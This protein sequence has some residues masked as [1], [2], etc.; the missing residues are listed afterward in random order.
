[1]G[2][3]VDV[4]IVGAGIA[5]ASLAYE[6]A[7]N[8]KVAL[9]EREERP[10][11]HST[12]RSA[13]MLIASYG[14]APVR[15]LTAASRPLFEQP[16]E[17]FSPRALLSPR[18]H[19]TIAR[20]DQLERLA[21]VEAETRPAVPSLQ[22]LDRAGV[23]QAASLVAEDY[24]AAGLYEPDSMAIDDAALHQGY[25]T[26]FQK[27]GGALRT[28]ADVLKVQPG[29][30]GAWRVETRAGIVE[31]DV[32][33]N[34]AGAWADGL[35]ALAGVAPIGIR[36]LRRTAVLIEPPAGIEAH[37]LPMIY[38]VGEGFYVKPEGAA[39][40]VSPADQTPSEPTD[41]QPEELDVA[42]AVDRYET[43]TGTVVK[44]LGRR[45][46]GLRSFS[47]DR[48]LVLGFDPAA[49]GFFWLAGQGGFGIMTAPGAARLAASLIDKRAPPDALA[50]LAPTLSPA[51]FRGN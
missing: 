28:D 11:Y 36:P 7:G 48:E 8:C 33:V 24:P 12:G 38:D 9:L 4:V 31:A 5:G 17:G 35:A 44:K 46:A 30:A 3:V 47:P 26:G 14:T 1:M 16:P 40:M 50:G 15:A 19:L 39:F 20:K 29:A 25:L 45:W 13:A 49:Q 21:E 42:I 41:A 27:K 37:D 43:L 34:A 32:V 23:L 18:A 22:R 6:L 51:R 10:G 2:D